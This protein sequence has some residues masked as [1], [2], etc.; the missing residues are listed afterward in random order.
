[1]RSA[2]AS[3]LP[4]V[5]SLTKLN[6][7][8]LT[9]AELDTP[10]HTHHSLCFEWNCCDLVLFKRILRD[11]GYLFFRE[12][13]FHTSGRIVRVDNPSMYRSIKEYQNVFS[14]VSHTAEDG[15]TY[16]YDFVFG[17]N[18][19]TYIIL[20]NNPSQV[21]WMWR[22]KKV[23]NEN[24]TP[25]LVEIQRSLD[26]RLYSDDRMSVYENVIGDGF[27]TPGG[28]RAA[29]NLLSRLTFTPQTV[30][31]DVGCGLGG[32]LA[33]MAKE[34]AQVDITGLELSPNAVQASI[35]LM[36]QLKSNKGQVCV[37]DLAQT[38]LPDGCFDIIFVK[39]TIGYLGNQTSLL[40]NFQKWLKPRGQLLVGDYCLGN[41]PLTDSVAKVL[42]AEGIQPLDSL[43]LSQ[44]FHDSGYNPISCENLS[45][46]CVQFITE[47]LHKLEVAQ[48]VSD[49]TKLVFKTIWETLLQGLETGQ[50]QWT[51]LVATKPSE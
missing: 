34:H 39:D 29:K 42:T 15:T 47:D 4:T 8:S 25:K 24:G 49:M 6:V 21:Y 22:K 45:A 40:L 27:V 48:N 41:S 11:G 51:V 10:H 31:L 43:A 50:L 3:N 35:L 1:M 12:S 14:S 30:M 23:V 17:G 28:L 32:T 7:N 13:C 37:S 33:Y 19:Q 2:T 36:N 20:K 44:V 9:Q 26:D 46:E 5:L 16:C 18:C 38:N